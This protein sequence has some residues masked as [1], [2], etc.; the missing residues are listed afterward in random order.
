MGKDNIVF[1]SVIW[2]ALLLGQNGAGRPR[3]HARRV[4]HAEPA[5][6][7]RVVGVPHDERLEVLD[8]PRHRHLRRR[9][10]ARVRPR[11][12]ALLHRGR[13]AGEPGHRLHLGRVRPPHQLRAR[14]RV[15]QPGQP[16]DLDGAQERRGGPEAGRA[17]R[18]RRRAARDLP[19]RRSTRSV[20]C[21]GA[22]GSSRR[23]ARRCGWSRRPT[24]TCRT[25]SRG[26][27]RT[28]PTG[29]TRSCTPRC[30]SSRTRTRCSRRSCRT[31]R[32]RCTRRSAA[33]GCGR[34]S[35]RSGRST[36]SVTARPTR[37]SPATTRASRRGGQSTPIE[38]GRPLA[39]PTPI[40]SKLDPKL[41][42]TGPEWAPIAR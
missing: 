36:T 7:D 21:S 34:R 29:A 39:R 9:L 12:P 17:R 13:R 8:E 1:H 15:G 41:G 11:R 6:R 27:A 22:T 28:I 2:P 4:R 3:R 26:S 30:R 42:E 20:A 37:S 24:G 40:F 16:V 25:R 32:S 35:R 18:R 10:P 19:R 5:E 33:A 31:R 14:Q 23:S 38:V